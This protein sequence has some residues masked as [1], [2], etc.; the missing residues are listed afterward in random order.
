[1]NLKITCSVLNHELLNIII[2]IAIDCNIFNEVKYARHCKTNWP[3]ICTRR[4]YQVPSTILYLLNTGNTAQSG[5]KSLRKCLQEIHF[6]VGA[7]SS[8]FLV[9]P[10]VISTHCI[11]PACSSQKPNEPSVLPIGRCQDV[12]CVSIFFFHFSVM[13]SETYILT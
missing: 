13:L 7:L 3:L 4:K 12:L 1:M 9:S 10:N 8:P 11:M 5:Y 6:P 2:I